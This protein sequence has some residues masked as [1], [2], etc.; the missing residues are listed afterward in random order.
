MRCRKTNTELDLNAKSLQ[1]AIKEAALLLKKYRLSYD[2][3][4]YVVK[5]ARKLVGLGRPT[6]PKLLPKALSTEELDRFFAAVRKAG[7]AEHELLYRLFLVTGVRCAEMT[8]I[9]RSDVSLA[10]GTIR[11]NCGKG[12]KDRVVL[13]NAALRLPLDLHMRATE[14]QRFLFE[15][16]QRKKFSTRWIQALTKSYGE[17]AGLAG[18]HVH[19]LRHTALTKLAVGIVTSNGE[20]VRLSDAQI[21]VQSGHSQRS[22]LEVYTQLG[23]GNIRDEFE[24]IMESKD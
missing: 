4:L 19:L 24:K 9:L 17:T 5:T 7:K 16:R 14:G 21:Q 3:S 22:S 13:F 8:H 18:M 12:G 1:A 2:Q 23:L 11:I 20:R 10:D 6:K 15:T